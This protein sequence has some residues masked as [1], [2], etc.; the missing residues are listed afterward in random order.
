MKVRTITKEETQARLIEEM[1]A[2]EKEKEAV[3]DIKK[4]IDILQQMLRHKEYSI[5]LN[6]RIIKSMQEALEEFND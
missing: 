5:K 2:N 1:L 4:Q 6:E 3:R